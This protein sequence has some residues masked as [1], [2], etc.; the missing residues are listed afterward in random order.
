M[1]L[2]RS[3]GG[4]VVERFPDD[5]QP[6]SENPVKQ[7]GEQLHAMEKRGLCPISVFPMETLESQT[8]KSVL[9]SAELGHE[10]KH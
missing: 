8:F 4:R 9:N 10:I 7:Q 6:E 2:Q 1:A 5:R 3:T